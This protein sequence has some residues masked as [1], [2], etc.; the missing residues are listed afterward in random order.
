MEDKELNSSTSSGGDTDNAAANK[1]RSND[2]PICSVCDT[3]SL[4]CTPL[5]TCSHPACPKCLA[6][7]KL[8]SED[9]AASTCRTCLEEESSNSKTASTKKA[10][11]KAA[12]M[13]MAGQKSASSEVDSKTASIEMADQKS[14]PPEVL[15]TRA[16]RDELAAASGSQAEGKVA[17]HLDQ[18]KKAVPSQDGKEGSSEKGAALKSTQNLQRL[19]KS[20]QRLSSVMEMGRPRAISA[21]VDPSTLKLKRPLPAE[22]KDPTLSERVLKIQEALSGATKYTHC[23]ACLQAKKSAAPESLCLNCALSFCQR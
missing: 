19:E 20:A 16:L 7:A 13:E 6:I 18:A 14:A 8:Q 9:G 22:K 11:Q 23:H 15:Q 1:Y 5:P 4:D 2:L 17:G 12:S 3:V 10:E 21:P